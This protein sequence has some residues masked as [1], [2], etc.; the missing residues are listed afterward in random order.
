MPDEFRNQAQVDEFSL[1]VNNGGFHLEGA[2][3]IPG[4]KGGGYR[5][6]SRN[7]G[8]RA[9]LPRMAGKEARIQSDR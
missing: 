6:F 7:D 9:E 4:L 1:V 2:S 5:V 8:W 3:Q